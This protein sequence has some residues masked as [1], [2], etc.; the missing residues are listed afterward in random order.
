[1]LLP[2]PAPRPILTALLR[3][4]VSRLPVP[5]PVAGPPVL[6]ARPAPRPILTALLRDLHVKVGAVCGQPLTFSG[7][8]SYLTVQLQPAPEVS[9]YIHI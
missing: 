7:T 2:R 9:I 6:L 4:C 5:P 8:P 1:M 3:D